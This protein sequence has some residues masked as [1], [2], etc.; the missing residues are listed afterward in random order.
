MRPHRVA[1][2][3]DAHDQ[4]AR[5]TRGEVVDAAA[6]HQLAVVDDRHRLAEIL[7]EIEL[8]TG[9]QD[10][11]SGVCA[12]DE[13]LADVVYTR[14]VKTRQRFVEHDQLGLVHERRGE[15][16]SLLIAV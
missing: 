10:T 16:Y 4:S 15:L 6:C 1:V 12:L 13:N 8:M 3:F 2:T 9:E 5:T 11:T 7:D 14:W